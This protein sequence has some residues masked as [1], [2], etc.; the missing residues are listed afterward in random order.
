[1]VL[2]Q[3][4]PWFHRFFQ[5]QK[6]EVK[7]YHIAFFNYNQQSIQTVV[8]VMNGKEVQ[9]QL[10]EKSRIIALLSKL[11]VKW[12]DN[13]QSVSFVNDQ[14]NQDSESE[15]SRTHVS[16]H[17]LSRSKTMLPLKRLL[18]PRPP[19]DTNRLSSCSKAPAPAI[20]NEVVDNERKDIAIPKE[21]ETSDKLD[22][23]AFLDTFTETTEEELEKI[24][25]TLVGKSGTKTRGY[26]CLKCSEQSK[27]F[28]IAEK[29]NNDHLHEE[30]RPVREKMKKADLDRQSYELEIVKRRKLHSVFF[31][32]KCKF[33]LSLKVSYLIPKISLDHF[34]FLSIF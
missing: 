10:K 26:K 16:E 6:F 33:R 14:E 23:Y 27:Y 21:K 19:V 13:S 1:M 30:L 25:H 28:T 15:Q 8:D 3:S 5:A 2:A 22:L 31:I 17:S 29:H 12:E 20:T 24:N 34:L 7:E 9:I 4:S 11:E 32:R 18:P